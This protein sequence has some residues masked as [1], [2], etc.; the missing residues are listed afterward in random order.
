V[1]GYLRIGKHEGAKP[2]IGGERATAGELAQGYFDPPTVFDQVRPDMRIA[3][4]EIFGPVVTAIP[5]RTLDEVMRLSSATSYGLAGG[6][7]T[8]DSQK[9]HRAARAMQPGVVW[10]NC[11]NVFDPAMPF[12]GYKMSGYGRESGQQ[13]LDLYT[14]VKAVWMKIG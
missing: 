3:R 9:A 11:Y 6:I 14:P 12:G 5:F 4:E 2:L 8:R 1:G 10:V 7:W 13:A